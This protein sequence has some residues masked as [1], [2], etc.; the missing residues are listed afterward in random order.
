MDIYIEF[1]IIY[2]VNDHSQ[3]TPIAIYNWLGIEY[4][5]HILCVCVFAF[6][7][8][9]TTKNCTTSPARIRPACAIWRD[10][11]SKIYNRVELNTKLPISTWCGRCMC[12][13]HSRH[14]IVCHV[15]DICLIKITLVFVFFCFAI[16]FPHW[17]KI[18]W[19]EIK[20]SVSGDLQEEGNTTIFF[21][22]VWI[23]WSITMAD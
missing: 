22:F 8:I 10:S 19:N 9:T 11:W 21:S 18:K 15:I 4:Y 5:V 1:P 20:T 14:S 6:P 16:T 17:K 13:V 23:Y 12:A 7:L 2:G 3:Y